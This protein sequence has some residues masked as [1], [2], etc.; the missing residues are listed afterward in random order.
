MLSFYK[1]RK[2]LMRQ[3]VDSQYADCSDPESS[4]DEISTIEKEIAE[5]KL[6]LTKASFIHH[7]ISI[8]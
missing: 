5:C 2:R 4:D 6:Q 8:T 3:R 1:L 7:F